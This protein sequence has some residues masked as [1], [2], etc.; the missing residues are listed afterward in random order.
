MKTTPEKLTIGRDL[1]LQIEKKRSGNRLLVTLSLET[2]TKCKL[3]W[4]LCRHRNAPWQLPPKK[5][6]PAKTQRV[7]RDALQTDFQ[8]RDAQS[9]ITLELPQDSDFSY[10]A[11]VLYFPDENFWDNNHGQNYAIRLP[12]PDESLLTPGQALS[13]ET[14]GKEIVFQQIFSLANDLQ[15]A[16][17]VLQEGDSFQISLVTDIPGRLVLHWGITKKSRFEWLPPSRPL[18]PVETEMADDRAAQTL[19]TNAEGFNRLQFVW[20]RE[21]ALTGITFVLY[22]PDSRQ[23]LQGEQGNFYIPVQTPVYKESGLETAIL[24]EVTDE[25]VAKEMGRNSW[26][27]MHR[28][29]LC[30]D[31]LDRVGREPHGLALLFIWL[32]FS[33]IRQLDWQ[34][35]YNTQPRELSHAQKRLTVKLAGLYRDSGP[36][37]REVIRLLLTTVG[38][39]G[40]GGRGQRVRDEILEI[41]HRHK[42]KEVTGHFMEE[43]HQKLHNNATADDIVICEAYLGFLRSNG[44]RSLFYKILADGGVSKKRLEGF[45]RP[46]VTDPDFVPHIKD[47]LIYDFEN[48]LKLLKSVHSAT[49]LFSALEA[50]GHCLDNRLRDQ[51]ASL[52]YGREEYHVGVRER[53]SA[54]TESTLR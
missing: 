17:A 29:N 27:L 45:E 42:I 41:M 33:A 8:A 5:N 37:A 1:Q 18:R 46:I 28:F 15:L 22:L 39:G 32:R 34:R 6:W 26:T 47:G 23:W 24:V 7:G 2:M 53:V 51:V 12:R 40:E 52:Y 48:Y 21:E 20:P 44:D 3:H 19:F 11:F 16:T 38:R 9:F 54:I 43:W 14:T 35:N 25:I 10:L 36:E 30:H 50:A 49:D 13:A 31:L 4:G